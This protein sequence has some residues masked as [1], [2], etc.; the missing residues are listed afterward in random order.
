MSYEITQEKYY[1][2]LIFT[3]SVDKESVLSAYTA[4]L[5]N[6]HFKQETHT[7]WDIRKAS[8]EL[9][10]VDIKE[11]ASS[12]T[13]SSDERSNHSRC[14][15]V[16]IDPTDKSTIQ[17]Y[18]TATAHYPVEFRIFEDFEKAKNWVLS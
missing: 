16:V 14:A 18:I 12:V 11:L 9:S 10:F 2:V 13:E 1:F 3:G 7:I 6:E 5:Q 15:Y 8:A 17:S 4:L